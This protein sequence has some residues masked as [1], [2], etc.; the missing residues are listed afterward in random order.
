MDDKTHYVLL[1]ILSAQLKMH[2]SIQDLF[3]QV[4]NP[5]L[6]GLIDK[7]DLKKNIDETFKD[8]SKAIERLK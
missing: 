8:I 1:D 3:Y 2:G 4:Y 5:E 6:P 7:N